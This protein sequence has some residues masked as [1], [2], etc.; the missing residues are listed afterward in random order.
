MVEVP[1]SHFELFVELV[2][3]TTW[4]ILVAVVLIAF[5]APLRDT[6]RQIP[7][8]LSRSDTVTIAGLSL[9]LSPGLR[10]QASP[11]VK[12]VLAELSQEA[13]KRLLSMGSSTWWDVGEESRG[14]S[15]NAELVRLNLVEEVPAHEIKKLNDRDQ[16]NF[17]YGVRITELGRQTQSFLHSVVAEFVK[18][19]G[20]STSE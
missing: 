6:A 15:E 9:K 19:L 18:E 13:I 14:R 2:K 1:K 16:R 7:S 8:L 4:P 17:C 11:D 12:K 20:H 3:A 10:H 5:W